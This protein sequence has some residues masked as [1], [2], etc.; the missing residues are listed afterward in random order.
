MYLSL[1]S[2]FAIAGPMTRRSPVQSGE[3]RMCV[4]VLSGVAVGA[5]F[6]AAPAAAGLAA[7]ATSAPSANTAVRRWSIPLWLR[8]G[9]LGAFP[10]SEIPD[11]LDDELRDGRER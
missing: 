11:P 1:E 7:S 8:P 10:G 6:A 5:G 2:T 9:R 3:V 4:I